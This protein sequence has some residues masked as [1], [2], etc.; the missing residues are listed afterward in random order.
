M[1]WPSRCNKLCSILKIQTPIIQAPM[2]GI[3]NPVFTA[4]ASNVG[5]LGSHGVGYRS[6]EQLSNEVKELFKLTDGKPFA[7][8]IFVKDPPEVVPEEK[9]LKEVRDAL[10]QFN[11]AVGEERGSSVVPTWQDYK[12]HM[13]VLLEHKVPVVSTTFGALSESEVRVL[14]EN[15]SVVIGTATCVEEAVF[16]EKTGVDVIVVQGS[17]AGGHRGTFACD[18]NDA[19]I[20]TMTLLP[21]VV[22]AV[23]VPVLAAGGI[24]DGRGVAAALSLGAS[25]ACLGTAFVSC[26]ESSAVP[27]YKV[28]LTD[29][30]AL[31]TCITAAY[32]GRPARAICNK[33]TE[34]MSTLPKA[35]F[36]IQHALTKGLRAKAPFNETS[37]AMYL[38]GQGAPSSR[39]GKVADVARSIIKEAEKTL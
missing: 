34:A 39:G 31:K 26:D 38:I 23:Q 27:D 17:E 24:M 25:G 3:S 21:Q 14:H 20:G 32:S 15:G 4:E 22:D 12:E 7:I 8:N 11:D 5:I 1:T 28:A 18:F 16:L 36:P 6:V 2:A 37:L 19:M 13:K 30:R 29:G 33:Y 35:P 9:E 10:Q